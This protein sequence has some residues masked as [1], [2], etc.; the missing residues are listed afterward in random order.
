MREPQMAMSVHLLC[1]KEA[2]RKLVDPDL[3]LFSSKPT[4]KPNRP[5]DLEFGEDLEMREPQMAMSV[6]LV[7]R[8]HD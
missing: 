8:H 6:N 5:R 3:G 2:P 7:W 1:S 4:P